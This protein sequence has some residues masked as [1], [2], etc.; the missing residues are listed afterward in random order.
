MTPIYIYLNNKYSC[1][2]YQLNVHNL[3]SIPKETCEY[4][5][6]TTKE[7]LKYNI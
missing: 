3:I 1:L 7:Y 4:S 6:A 2:T 5:P